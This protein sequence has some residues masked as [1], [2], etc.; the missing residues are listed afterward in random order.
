[1]CPVHG[2]PLEDRCSRCMAG[3]RCR[4]RAADG[5]AATGMH[6]VASGWS[7][8]PPHSA[9]N[10]TSMGAFGVCL[11][12]ALIRLAGQLPRRPA[13][14]AGRHTAQAAMGLCA[15]GQRP[16]YRRPEPDVLHRHVHKGE[17]RASDRIARSKARITVSDH[18]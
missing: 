1:M 7:I 10:D 12:P 4:F 2:I 13:G 11:T 14:C 17:M 16:E 9:V 6:G 5:P 15:V 8:P 18:L 3:A